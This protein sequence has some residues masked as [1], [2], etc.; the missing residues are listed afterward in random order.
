M[1]NRTKTDSTSN[2][3]FSL[4]TV[5][6]ALAFIGILAMLSI[7]LS[8]AN[9]RMKVT[10]MK[11]KDNFYTAEQALE[12]IRVG[13]QED[14]GNA[15][16]QAYTYVLENYSRISSQEA[17]MDELRQSVF[18]EHYVKELT[19]FLKE[20][21]DTTKYDLV[22]LISYIDQGKDLLSGNPECLIVV[23]P[24]GKAPEMQ[25]D[26]ERGVLLK[27][28][29]VIYVDAKGI[30]SI[31][32]TDIRLGIPGVQFPTPSTLPDL[33]ELPM[34]ANGGILCKGGTNATA[35]RDN[36]I[37]I[38]GNVYAGLLN[39][40]ET[41]AS[42]SLPGKAP[43][44]IKVEGNAHVK[45]G[46]GERLVCQGDIQVGEQAG[47]STDS[48]VALWANGISLA[49]AAVQ[50]EGKTYLA[51]DLTVEKGTNSLV[52]LSGEY[53][54]YGTPESA[55]LSQNQNLFNKWNLS[56]TDKSSAITINGKNTTMDLSG[57]QKIMLSGKN[58][59]GTS[60]LTGT[61]PGTSKASID[62]KDVMMG[63]SLT[64]KGTQLAYLAPSSLLYDG[65]QNNPMTYDE[66]LEISETTDVVSAGTF[67]KPQEMWNGKSMAQLGLNKTT[68]VKSVFYND[69]AGKGSVYFYLNFDPEDSS[70]AAQVAEASKHAVAYMQEYFLNEAMKKRMDAYLDFYL[71]GGGI[72]LNDPNTYLRYITNGN[73]LSYE[74]QQDS[75][76]SSKETKRLEPATNTDMNILNGEQTGY[77]NMW[78]A[79]NRNMRNILYKVPDPNGSIKGSDGNF[80]H[81]ETDENRSVYDNRVNEAEMLSFI[82]K[83]KDSPVGGY[84]NSY[85][86]TAPE[87][88]GGLTA[89]M[90]HNSG[91]TLTYKVKSGSSVDGTPTYEMKSFSSTKQPF[92]ITSELAQKL[93][94]VVCT[95][96]VIIEEGVTF[97]G[98]IM[99]N[100][101]I[102]LNP[103]AKLH[104][105]PLEA[106][107]VFQAQII[108]SSTEEDPISPKDFF[109][110]E[111]VLGNSQTTEN[112]TQTGYLSD[113]YA[114]SD[115][116]NYEN[117]KKK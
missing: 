45:V 93:R 42:S 34:V 7:Y 76:Q 111:Y 112:G 99:A 55:S 63:E 90:M 117:W 62:N 50:L 38:H 56:D 19:G 82:F 104:S 115:Y 40:N 9:L 23:N 57:L 109:W 98:I 13:L 87:A 97:S 66:Y 64:V 101:T 58:Y 80:Y 89:V 68:P 5:I 44:S 81:D 20:Q 35:N 31:I 106:A 49:S 95:G 79:L 53:Y 27:N 72:T 51:D 4:F 59:I 16:A 12:E 69:N 15:M 74:T 94:L 67:Q 36:P 39:S 46:T 105:A 21:N 10:D 25:A 41:E 26:F 70:D 43:V 18:R 85:F 2:Q 14:V 30:A 47:F 8:M 60:S 113:I 17:S 61:K 77:Q 33:K 88:D 73:M 114:V 6:V 32:E 52:T 91:E 22:H 24:S 54:G 11:H 78:Y 29:K 83:H 71:K 96:D 108:G 86:F 3:G 100:G 84:S 75:G 48:T 110:E 107:K 28:L 1:K 65:K 102:T 116:V 103:G 92:T 37:E